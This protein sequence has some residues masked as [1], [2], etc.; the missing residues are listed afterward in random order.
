[1]KRK[2]IYRVIAIAYVIV[3]TIIMWIGWKHTIIPALHD[4]NQS[5]YKTY[6]LFIIPIG[7]LILLIFTL[8]WV[9]HKKLDLYSLKLCLITIVMSPFV[10][11]GC[12]GFINKFPVYA[13]MFFSLNFMVIGIVIGLKLKGKKIIHDL[14]SNVSG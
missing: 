1:M 11:L 3:L 8:Y 7:L 6:F 4:I 9:L 13:T 10:V 12:M 5:I 14:E 2:N